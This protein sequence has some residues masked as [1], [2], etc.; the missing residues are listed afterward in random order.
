[1]SKA[2]TSQFHQPPPNL[3]NVDISKEPWETSEFDVVHWLIVEDDKGERR[4]PLGGKVYSIGRDSNSDIRL[5]SMFVSRRHATLV[6]QKRKDGSCNYQIVDG[7]LEGKLSANGIL[8]NGRKLP[9]PNIKNKLAA[10]N[11]KHQDKIIFGAGV[12]AIY[13]QLDRQQRRTDNQTRSLDPLDDI[14]LIDPGMID[15]ED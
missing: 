5:C 7:D 13:H 15:L 12:S 11:L 8:I 4:Y 14:T 2:K 3:S 9:A 1:M 10:Q 6:R